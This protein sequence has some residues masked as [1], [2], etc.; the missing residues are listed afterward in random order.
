MSNRK[1]VKPAVPPSV[2]ALAR[3]ARCSDCPAKATVKWRHGDWDLT[4]HHSPGCPARNGITA[5]LH[6]DAAAATT[7]AASRSGAD[8]EYRPLGEMAGIVTGGGGVVT[9][10]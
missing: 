6:D 7:A 10:R 5:T 4:L 3:E 2:L 1:N 8:L 9:G